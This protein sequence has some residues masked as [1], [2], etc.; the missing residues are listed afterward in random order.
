[1]NCGAFPELGLHLMALRGEAWFKTDCST[2]SM[3]L[4][5]VHDDKMRFTVTLNHSKGYYSRVS[6]CREWWVG[7]GSKWCLQYTRESSLQHIRVC[8]VCCT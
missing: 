8:H 7:F 4:V 3:C 5:G 6:A 2:R 1:M